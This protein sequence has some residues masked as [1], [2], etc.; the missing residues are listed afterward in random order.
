MCPLCELINDVCFAYFTRVLCGY[1]QM[2]FSEQLIDGKLPKTL[3]LHT[4]V[5]GGQVSL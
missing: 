3:V 4:N 5:T 1:S 2:G